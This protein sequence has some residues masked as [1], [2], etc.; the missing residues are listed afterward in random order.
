MADKKEAAA[1]AEAAEMQEGA[2]AQPPKKK[3][4]RGK[5]PVLIMLVAV[6]A[7]GG[8]FGMKVR[9]GSAPPKPELGEVVPLAEILVNLKDP[10]TYLRTEISV[11]H[12]IILILT[13]KSIREVRSVDGKL[14]LTRE[15]AS[16]INELFPGPTA[17]PAD[18]KA[19]KNEDMKEPA[20]EKAAPKLQNP[21]W[22]SDTGPV[23]KVYFTNF[24]TQ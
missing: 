24:A 7:G 13:S 19:R 6:L 15:I 16:R 8:F 17:K 2:E 14:A 4:K 12:R 3:R 11:R 9:G 10:N 21:D 22:D 18:S 5:L 1:A 20:A 23:L